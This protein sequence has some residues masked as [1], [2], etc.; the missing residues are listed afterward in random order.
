MRKLILI[1]SP[2]YR[3]NQTRPLSLSQT[4]V[5]LLLRH[6]T[7]LRQHRYLELAGDHRCQC[8]N[9][10]TQFLQPIKSPTDHLFYALRHTP[11]QV[12]NP[13]GRNIYISTIVNKSNNL[14]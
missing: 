13:G 14:A 5:K 9:G 3:F 7:R 2:W 6:F 11:Q 12:L 4:L 1:H 10:I 8:K